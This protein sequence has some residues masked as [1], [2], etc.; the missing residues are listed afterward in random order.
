MPIAILTR[1][2]CSRRRVY[3]QGL[4]ARLEREVACGFALVISHP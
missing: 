1:R 3:G 2:S 4:R